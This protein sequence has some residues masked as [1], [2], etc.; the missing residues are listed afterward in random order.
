MIIGSD[1]VYTENW[2][3]LNG[4]GVIDTDNFSPFPKNPVIAKFFQ[5][6]GWVDELRFRNT[7]HVPV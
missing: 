6:Y 1:S 4:G 5:E 7:E 2:I 3:R